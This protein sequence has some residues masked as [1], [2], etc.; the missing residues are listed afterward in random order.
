MS[1][2]PNTLLVV[3]TLAVGWMVLL[4]L[5][6]HLRWMVHLAALPVGLLGWATAVAMTTVVGAPLTMSLALSG[7]AV[8]V[9]LF[10]S[11]SVW[12]A[13]RAPAEGPGF[14]WW[15]FA[16]VG[17]A[18]VLLGEGVARLGT[19][20]ATADS[21]AN[22]EP[23]GWLLHDTGVLTSIVLNERNVL[24]PAMHAAGR[25]FGT[26]VT[27][28]IYQVLA[29]VLAALTAHLVWAS[30]AGIARRWKF[31]LTGTTIAVIVSSPVWLYMSM[32]I[33]SHIISATYLLLGIGAVHRARFEPERARGPW[34]MLAG[35]CS[36]GLALARPDGLAYVFVP[37]L[38][39]LGAHIGLGWS[40]RD[41]LAF[42]APLLTVLG[43]TFGAAL[44]RLG[45]WAP[46]KLSGAV[47]L[48]ALVALALSAF[49]PA[50]V[51]H[52]GRAGRWLATGQRFSL[53]VLAAT[54]LAIVGVLALRPEQ[55][56][57]AI[58]NIYLNLTA[59]GGW[60]VFWFATA[61]ALAASGLARLVTRPAAWRDALG[62]SV[63]QF[64]ALALLVHAGA[65][66]GR[67][68]WGDSFNRVV[69]HVVPLAFWFIA[70][71]AGAL[72]PARRGSGA[73]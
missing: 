35:L 57:L 55:G 14:S 41:A 71:S 49:A 38:V 31:V 28:A 56:P 19:Y 33:H 18:V 50:A 61:F 12:H 52:M 11:L 37:V 62:I 13:R 23:M 69:F 42:Y 54:G 36:A 24:I 10:G 63:V 43:L 22:Y 48:A 9:G 6:N 3:A 66:P 44:V 53:V 45:L 65:H 1:L 5:K 60:G 70:V 15:T 68:Y 20:V 25:S 29:V 46:P 16:A 39:Y 40:R 32:Y 21:W 26:E 30:L 73:E 7:A 27:F 72:I 51:R 34:L 67:L 2:A 58:A 8:F 4:P 64:F 17:A 59:E 47:A